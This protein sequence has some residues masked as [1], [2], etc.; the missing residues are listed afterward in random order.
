MTDLHEYRFNEAISLAHVMYKTLNKL[1]HIYVDPSK[2][3]YYLSTIK[4]KETNLQYIGF[5]PYHNELVPYKP[6]QSN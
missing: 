4:V 2:I 1:V 6:T 3:E 5:Y